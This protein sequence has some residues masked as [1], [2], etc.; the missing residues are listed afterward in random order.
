MLLSISFENKVFYILYNK[1]IGFYYP[2][3]SC[4][5]YSFCLQVLRGEKKVN[6]YIML[7]LIFSNKNQL[8][9][10]GQVG[11]YSLPYISKLNILTKKNLIEQFN[12]DNELSKYI[13]NNC[14]PTT[15]T[16][17]FI[18]SL[19]FN[20]RRDKYLALYE[21]YKKAKLQQSTTNGKIYEININDEYAKELND[22]INVNR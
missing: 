20:V 18:L 16:R 7:L 8:L 21:T 13:P 12:N 17:S 10:L 5:N 15:I 14:N 4:F 6:K 9:K 2:K 19:L 1:F 3:F 11:G 22:F